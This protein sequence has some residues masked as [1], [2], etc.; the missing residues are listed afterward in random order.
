[1][2]TIQEK[3]AIRE[4]IANLYKERD[5]TIELVLR[6]FKEKL[7]SDLRKEVE[8]CKE[9]GGHDWDE[10]VNPGIEPKDFVICIWCG[11]LKEED[12]CQK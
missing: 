3:R 7:H 12:T 2:T 8:F 11:T 10:E 4:R 5:R 1:M 6:A 9:N